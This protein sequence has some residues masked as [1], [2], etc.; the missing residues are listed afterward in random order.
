MIDHDLPMPFGYTEGWRGLGAF[1]VRQATIPDDC[2]A[3][4]RSA[5]I[6]ECLGRGLPVFTEKPLLDDGM[7]KLSYTL[8][9]AKRLCQLVMFWTSFDSIWVIYRPLRHKVSISMAERPIHLT[10]QASQ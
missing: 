4:A 2:P 1:Q 8:A 10:M 7:D 3:P 6:T 9:E 5:I